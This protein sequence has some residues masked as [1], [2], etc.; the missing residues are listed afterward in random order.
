MHSLELLTLY[1]S[2]PSKTLALLLF[3]LS[4]CS[5]LVQPSNVKLQIALRTDIDGG[6]RKAYV[7]RYEMPAGAVSQRHIHPGDELVYVVEGDA[8]VRFDDGKRVRFSKGEAI[9]IPPNLPH[10]DV[11]PGTQR[12]VVIGFVL[13]PP[14]KMITSL[15]AEK[16]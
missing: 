8:E 9:H 16:S 6:K 10:I 14:G 12:L 4:G 3:F 5:S 11:N 15:A 1:Y 13:A 2:L 7:A